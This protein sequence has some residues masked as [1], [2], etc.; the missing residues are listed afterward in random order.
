MAIPLI[1]PIDSMHRA[2]LDALDKETKRIV[3]EEAQ[4]AAARVVERVRGKTGE[5]AAKLASYVDYRQMQEG[6]I[7]TVRF[8]NEPQSH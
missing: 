5:I 2:V 4:A 7:I 3:E 1:S 8:P 6:L